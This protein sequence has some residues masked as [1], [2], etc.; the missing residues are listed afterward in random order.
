MNFTIQEYGDSALLLTFD[1]EINEQSHLHIIGFVKSL[2]GMSIEG[3]YGIVSAYTSVTIQYDF[4]KISCNELSNIVKSLRY[5]VDYS[6]ENKIIEIPV[7]YDSHFSIDMDYL[8]SYTELSRAQVIKIHTSKDYLVHMLGFTPGF[9]YL[10]GMDKRL[11]CPRRESPRVKVTAG[12]VGV[13][14]SQTGVYTVDSPGGWQLIGK[15][16][17]QIFD[18]NNTDDYFKVKQ[19]DMVRF[20]QISSAEYKLYQG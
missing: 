6:G 8:C 17:L 4:L 13:G 19:G 14:G 15:T 3:V 5:S 10:G 16:P 11:Q 9:F 2:K 20:Y 12:S 1:Q 7:C 18:K